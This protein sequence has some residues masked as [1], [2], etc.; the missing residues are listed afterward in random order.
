VVVNGDEADPF[1]GLV[2]I[3]QGCV[4]ASLG[5]INFQSIHCCHHSRVSKRTS[6]WCW[7]RT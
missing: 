3:K 5:L 4:L 2:G 7:N 1:A 6:I